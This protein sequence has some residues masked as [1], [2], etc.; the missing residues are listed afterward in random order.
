[1]GT[2]A[3]DVFDLARHSDPA[4]RERNLSVG[5]V[6]APIF[7][8][9]ARRSLGAGGYLSSKSAANSPKVSQHDQPPLHQLARGPLPTSNPIQFPQP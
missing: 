2:F 9:F 3:L 4:L 5:S 7:A 1:V 8:L 6:F